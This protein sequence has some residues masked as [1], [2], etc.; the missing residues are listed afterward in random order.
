MA[1]AILTKEVVPMGLGAES[2]ERRCLFGSARSD[3]ADAWLWDLCGHTADICA[4][5][6]QA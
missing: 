3:P 5:A 4:G 6:Y 1:V 2:D